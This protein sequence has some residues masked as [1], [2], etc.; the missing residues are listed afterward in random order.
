VLGGADLFKRA[1]KAAPG[2]MRRRRG[3]RRAKPDVVDG[4]DV[5]IMATMA[6]VVTEEVKRRFIVTVDDDDNI[7]VVVSLLLLTNFLIYEV[8]RLGLGVDDESWFMAVHERERR[9]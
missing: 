6:M 8:N 9:E 1:L 5:A 3:E 7:A 2:L 4:R